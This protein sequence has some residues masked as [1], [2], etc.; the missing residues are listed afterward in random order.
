MNT[1]A[2]RTSDNE[3]HYRITEILISEL[4]MTDNPIEFKVAQPPRYDS[5]RDE[6]AFEKAWARVGEMKAQGKLAPFPP[7]PKDG[8]KLRG[9]RNRRLSEVSL[10][11]DD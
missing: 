11:Q 8:I 10:S 6:P 2:N 3:Q 4:E 1:E 7:F 9:G 5:E